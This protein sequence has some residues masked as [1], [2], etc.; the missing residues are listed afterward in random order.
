MKKLLPIALLLIALTGCANA[1]SVGKTA[2]ETPSATP[3][4]ESV[5][6]W[7]GVVAEQQVTLDDWFGTWDDNTCSALSIEVWLCG[8]SIMSASYIT[9]TMHLGVSGASNEVSDDFLGEVPAEID[10]LYAETV[11]LTEEAKM[12]G[13]AWQSSTCNADTSGEGCISLAFTLENALSGVQTKFAAW[14]PY[15]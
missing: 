6:R 7:A 5:S 14:S 11:E 15:L 2:D 3:S 4:A 13:D 1:P 9:T 10:D 8:A 12:A